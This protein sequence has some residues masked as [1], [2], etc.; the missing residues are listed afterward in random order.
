LAGEQISLEEHH[1]VLA[2]RYSPETADGVVKALRTA[3]ESGDDFRGRVFPGVPRAL[4]VP[5]RTF[6]QWAAEHAAAFR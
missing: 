2:A 4:G 6:R 5:G 1:A 3:L